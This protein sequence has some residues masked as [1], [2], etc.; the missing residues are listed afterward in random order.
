MGPWTAVVLSAVGVQGDAVLAHFTT[1]VVMAKAPLPPELI[2]GSK[3]Y[4]S[5]LIRTEDRS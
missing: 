2:L 1:T 4:P 5:L 3:G